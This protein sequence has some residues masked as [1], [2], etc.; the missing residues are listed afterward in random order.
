MYFAKTSD[1]TDISSYE[2]VPA[3]A[4]CITEGKELTLKGFSD[5]EATVFSSDETIV[6]VVSDL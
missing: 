2:K 1:K 4:V 5:Q 3:A 6:S